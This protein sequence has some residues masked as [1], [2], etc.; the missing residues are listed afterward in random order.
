M[1]FLLRINF[2]KYSVWLIDVPSKCTNLNSVLLRNNKTKWVRSLTHAQPDWN[3][4]PGSEVGNED[5]GDH[6]PD[7]VHGRDDAGD[8]GGDLVALLDGRDHRVQIA[9]REGLLKGHQEWQQKN[10]NLKRAKVQKVVLKGLYRK[11]WCKQT[12]Y[13][14]QKKRRKQ[15]QD[16]HQHSYL[17]RFLRPTFRQQNCF[18]WKV[19]KVSCSVLKI[20]E[21]FCFIQQLI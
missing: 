18:G 9:G 6:V 19:Q 8:A 16:I 2:E 10:E 3:V 13:K 4:S 7:L 20:N 14:I 12:K 17:I 11:S 21:R 1:F 15:S 5:D